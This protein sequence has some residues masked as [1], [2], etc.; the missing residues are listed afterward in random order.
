MDAANCSPA[1]VEERLTRLESEFGPLEVTQTTF[2]VGAERYRSAREKARDGQVDVQVVV[3]D[4][5]GA[6]LLWEGDDGGPVPRGQTNP[7]EDIS[8]AVRRIV[9][10]TAGIECSVTDAKVAKIHGIRNS[11]DE[12]AETAYRLSVVCTAEPEDAAGNICESAH[13]DSDHDEIADLV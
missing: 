13:W 5:A 10:Q 9:R 6:A 4:G 1:S 8:A 12:A 11:A 3:R 2:E 7:E